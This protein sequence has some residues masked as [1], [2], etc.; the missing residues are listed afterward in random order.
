MAGVLH[1][2]AKRCSGS[3]LAVLGTLVV[4]QGWGTW[5]WCSWG[6]SCA[7]LCTHTPWLCSGWNRV[8]H[9]HLCSVWHLASPLWGR[10]TIN[11]LYKERFVRFT[12]IKVCKALFSAASR[13]WCWYTGLFYFCITWESCCDLLFSWLLGYLQRLLAALQSQMRFFSILNA[14]NLL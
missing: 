5:C 7:L 4:L 12:F 10:V 13:C 3:V 11:H 1:C 8:I 2:S 14:L 6:R 9:I